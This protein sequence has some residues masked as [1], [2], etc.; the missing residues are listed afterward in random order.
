MSK[1][2]QD[3][4]KVGHDRIGRV[5]SSAGLKVSLALVGV[6]MVVLNATAVTAGIAQFEP[7]SPSAGMFSE[8]ANIDETKAFGSSIALGTARATP[9]EKTRDFR[10]LEEFLENTGDLAEEIRRDCSSMSN[11]SSIARCS[12]TSAVAPNP[13]NKTE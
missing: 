12:G 1:H 8:P 3:S 7:S 9:I 5:S 4:V 6:I 10:N 11:L 2:K 13:A